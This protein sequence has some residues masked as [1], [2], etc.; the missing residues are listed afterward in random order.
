MA[1]HR[2]CMPLGRN[3]G[4]IN[5]D[6]E[7]AKTFHFCDP[8]PIGKDV[9]LPRNPSNSKAKSGGGTRKTVA[10]PTPPGPLV[11][12]GL[13]N[14]GVSTHPALPTGALSGIFSLPDN[15][16]TSGDV[17]DAAEVTKRRADIAAA[18]AKAKTTR[19]LSAANLQHWLDNTGTL[20]K[21]SSSDFLQGSSKLPAEILN[22]KTRDAFEKGI[23]ER[24][25]NKNH[26]QGTLLPSGTSVGDKGSVRFIQFRDG[27]RPSITGSNPGADL[28]TAVSAYL[29][30]SAAWVQATIKSKSGGFIGIGQDTTFEVTILQWWVQVMDVYDWNMGALTPILVN[31]ADVAN[32]PLPP[33]ALDDK[34]MV[35][36]VSQ[37]LLLLKDEY[38]RDL[39]VSGGG[40]SYYVFTD[41]FPA[42]KSVMSPFQVTL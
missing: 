9:A 42:P 41:P 21:M 37:R 8:G 1:P 29:A 28:A 33:E 24:L 14:A 5:L 20:L 38:F 39:E 10:G 40:K 34:G 19:P 31:P 36:G 12:P 30:H 16:G 22:F 4:D 32:I 23:K 3:P 18:I 15:P 17:L 7:K 25:K 13:K 27:D 6:R 2:H 35:P 26:P 11:M